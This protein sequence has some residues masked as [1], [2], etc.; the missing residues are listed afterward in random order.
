MQMN[1]HAR[2]AFKRLIADLNETKNNPVVGVSAHPLESNMFEVTESD[3][4]ATLIDAVALQLSV[5]GFCL[6][7]SDL[8]YCF[9]LPRE[10]P[11]QEPFGGICPIL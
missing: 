3:V 7:G 4:L 1:Q 5:A 11:F 10:L 9:V 6:W 8:S 2:A